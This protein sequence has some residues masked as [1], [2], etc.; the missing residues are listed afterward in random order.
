[1]KRSRL[2]EKGLK[3]KKSFESVFFKALLI[4]K[5]IIESFLKK[6]KQSLKTHL[7]E[8][9]AH[10]L[11]FVFRYLSEKIRHLENFTENFR[12][13]KNL[14]CISK[15]KCLKKPDKQELN[16]PQEVIFLSFLFKLLSENI[17]HFEN[18][19]YFFG[20]FFRGVL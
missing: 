8:I 19:L 2:R 14:S 1:V 11:S 3:I 15:D 13:E 18:S 16:K 6:V 9:R 4:S 12:A 20:V 7:E 5:N 17:R 10:V